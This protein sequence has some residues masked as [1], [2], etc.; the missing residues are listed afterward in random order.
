MSSPT[1]IWA[2]WK[3]NKREADRFWTAVRD[4]TGLA[5]NHPCFVAREFLVHNTLQR[6]QRAAAAVA[7]SASE[8]EI[9]VKMLNAWNAYREGRRLKHLIYQPNSSL[10]RLK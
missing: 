6:G 2:T 9:F 5:S 10:P 3:K 8:R 7:R 1:L 4:G